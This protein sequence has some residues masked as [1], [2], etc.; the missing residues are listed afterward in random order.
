MKKITKTVTALFLA[1]FFFS[2]ESNAQ[3]SVGADLG[4]FKTLTEGSEAQ[5]GV[6]FNVGY[7]INDQTLV[8]VNLG[9]YMKSYDFLGSNLTSFTIPITALFEYSFSDNDFSPYA[10]ANVGIY[11]FGISGLGE[12]T[13]SGYLGLAPVVGVNYDF[14][15]NLTFKGNLKYHYVITD[16]ESTS[17]FGI[18]AGLSYNF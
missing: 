7:S 12:T 18:N 2:Y 6:N 10:G 9:Y 14:S 8:G 15:N 17:A 11:R 1:A 13:A 16:V 4:M 3:V 5:L